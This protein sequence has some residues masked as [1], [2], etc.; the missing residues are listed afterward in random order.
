[1]KL[2]IFVIV[3]FVA[4]VGLIGAVLF[5]D[6][7]NRIHCTGLNGQWISQSQLCIRK[8]SIIPN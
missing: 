4:I 6:L 2:Y 1:M 7:D 8:E 3:F 5:N